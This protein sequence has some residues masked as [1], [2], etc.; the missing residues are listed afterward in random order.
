[1]KILFGITAGISLYKIPNV[2]R[3][4]KREG[5][6][7]KVI[8]TGNAAKLVSPL[9]FKAISDEEVYIRDFDQREP[10]AHIRL[11]DWADILAVAPASAN[12]L[13]KITA[14][15]ADNLLTSTIL[16][17]DKK[18]ILFPAMNT[19]MFEN[20][21]TQDNIQK[22]K[23][24]GF[25]IAEPEHGELACGVSGWG[26]LP[27]EE[28]IYGL[29]NRD[30][31]EPLKNFKFIVTAGGTI[32]KIDPVR[33]ISNF[34]SGKMGIEIAKALFKKGAGVLL[35]HARTSAAVP[36][37]IPSIY[38]ESAEDMLKAVKT[39]LESY[40][41]LYMAAAPADF[42][43]KSYSGKKVK[44]SPE[45]NLEFISTPDILK[46]VSAIKKEKLITGFALETD[47]GLENAKKKLQE[48]NLSFIVL[49]QIEKDF[50]PMGSDDNKV[51]L[52]SKDGAVIGPKEGGK[53]EIAEWL[54]ENTMKTF[55]KA[56]V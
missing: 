44:K 49:N 36:C 34:S 29:I 17:F 54:V 46:E 30:I 33:Y 52:I 10:L 14:G 56:G 32:E 1:M 38:S 28:K 13:A 9:L 42:K 22:L 41:G 43:A 24:R 47:K 5:H 12:T 39:N 26:R 2:I 25:L 3:M 55:I 20:T 53:K 48:K 11:G 51:I 50:Q 8:M 15:I 4:L 19:R 18:K 7:V 23:E 40:D 16:A 21:A 31:N 6:T 27:S 37:Y 35:I 45:L